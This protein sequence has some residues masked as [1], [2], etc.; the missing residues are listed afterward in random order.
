VDWLGR[1]KLRRKKCAARS[2]SVIAADARSGYDDNPKHR[3]AWIQKGAP[4]FNQRARP[5]D[6]DLEEQLNH[7][8]ADW[9]A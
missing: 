2:G 7:I 8:I 4:W 5:Q 1:R 6:W 9:N 3:E